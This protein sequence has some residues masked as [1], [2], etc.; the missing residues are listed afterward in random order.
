[1]SLRVQYARP[2]SA[3]QAVDLLGGL[4]AGAVVI[5]GGQELMPHLNHMRLTPSILVDISGLTELRDIH[6]HDGSV[7]IGALVVHREL[8]SSPAIREHV[9]LLAAA[10]AQVGGGW[11]VL[12]RGTIGGNLVA[13]HPL[14]DIAPALLALQADVEILSMGGPRRMTLAA[15]LSDVTLG[16]G[17]R[18]LLTRVIVERMGKGVGWS[19]QKLKITD[20]SYGSANAAALVE[21]SDGRIASLRMVLGAVTDKPVD[22]SAA[23]QFLIGHPPGEPALRAVEDRST[24]H[25]RDALSDHQGDARWRRAMAGVLARRAFAGAVACAIN[26]ARGG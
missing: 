20:G 24:E 4:G 6:R 11:Q 2:R 1:M 26:N 13:V 17:S 8:M 22:V 19:Y 15:M 23:L 18:D 16:L 7:S 3:R 12:N 25:I 9:P 21:V 10:A 5:A 14:Y